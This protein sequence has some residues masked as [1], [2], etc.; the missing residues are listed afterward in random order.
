MEDMAMK[1][2]TKT[3]KAQYPKFIAYLDFSSKGRDEYGVS[4]Y[5]KALK[6]DNII[7][8][9][10]HMEKCIS[11]YGTKIYL[12]DILQQVGEDAETGEPLYKTVIM[13]RV[14]GD[15]DYTASSNWHFRDKAHGETPSGYY[16][17]Y[18]SDSEGRGLLEWARGADED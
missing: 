2:L 1:K 16:K 7:D 10:R 14:H 4:T 11:L 12:A 5:T 13:T 8:A 18:S 6:Q 3:Q 17:W 15:E 9:M